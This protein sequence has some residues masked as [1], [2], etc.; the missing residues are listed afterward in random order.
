[1]Y[2]SPT[3]KLKIYDGGAFTTDQWNNATFNTSPSGTTLIDCAT[4][5]AF[6]KYMQLSHEDDT[7]LFTPTEIVT[8]KNFKVG[9]INFQGDTIWTGSSNLVINGTTM[10]NDDLYESLVKTDKVYA[11]RLVDFTGKGSSLTFYGSELWLKQQNAANPDTTKWRM[12]TLVLKDTEMKYLTYPSVEESGGNVVATEQFSINSN[13]TMFVRSNLSCSNITACNQVLTNKITTQGNYGTINFNQSTNIATTFSNIDTSSLYQNTNTLEYWTTSNSLSPV[14]QFSL[15][16]NGEAYIRSNVVMPFTATL[17]AVTAEQ[18]GIMRMT[19]NTFRFLTSNNTRE[20]I[21]FSVNSNGLFLP[22]KTSIYSRNETFN[23]PNPLDA[24]NPLVFNNFARLDMG[25]SNGITVG[26]NLSNDPLTDSNY[27]LFNISRFAELKTLDKRNNLM[28]MVVNSNS[29]WIGEINTLKAASISNLSSWNVNASNLMEDNQSLRFKY[30]FSNTL[31]NVEG[32]NRT[33]SNWS[34][35]ITIW[36]SNNTSNLGLKTQTDWT[37]NAL[38]NYSLNNVDKYW[39]FANS[40]VSTTS[41]VSCGNIVANDITANGNINWTPTK[42]IVC[43]FTGNNQECSIDLMNQNTHTG[44][45]FQVWSDKT[46]IGIM[47]CCRGDN[48]NIG[49]N[50]ASP[51]Y[52][53]DVNGDMR[54]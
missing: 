10:C 32:I 26:W 48:G 54:V 47:L 31:S 42:N 9:S 52:K 41:N 38:S 35:P 30:A 6:F 50:T 36:S 8:D 11:S 2:I 37:S 3:K 51:S 34:T 39:T 44:N 21:W 16:S 22:N 40:A 29:Q 46:N 28:T 49:V 19:S 7:T 15:N 18:E 24:L 53:L 27:D 43:S 45:S 5:E 17:R 23:M 13:G 1:L 12:S 25:L 14:K 20:D 33:F 4:R